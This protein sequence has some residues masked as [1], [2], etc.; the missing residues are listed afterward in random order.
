MGNSRNTEEKIRELIHQIGD[1]DPAPIGAMFGFELQRY[2]C[3]NDEAFF[4]CGTLPWMRNTAGML[5]GGISTAVL[6]QAMSF[7]A[8]ALKADDQQTMT[9]QLQVSHH[10]PIIP[11]KKLDVIVRK[12]SISRSFIHFYGEIWQNE[13]LSLSG[14]GIFY[15]K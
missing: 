6:D 1:M 7:V 10:R 3:D 13:K 9:I 8:R 11:E 2:Y 12:T 14:T 5:H 4:R 15:L